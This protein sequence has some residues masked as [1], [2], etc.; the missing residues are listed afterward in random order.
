METLFIYIAKSSGLIA[1]FFLAYYFLL[2]KE[3]FFTANR[4]FL[5][6]GLFTSLIL[7]WIVFTTI[8]WVDPTPSDIDWSKIPMTAVQEESF[9]INWYLVLAVA[10]IIGIVLFLVQFALDFYNLN[11][12]L[13][14]KTT[15]QQADHKFI[16][17][18]ENIAPFSYF[19]TI[20]YNSSLYSE[21]EMESILE[22]E[23]IHSEQYHTID[24]LITRF[25]CILFWFNPFI[26]LYKKAILQN[27]EFIAD[28]EASKNIS[29]KKAYQ[30]TLLKITAHENC[31]V[32]TNHFYQSLIKKRIVMLNKNQSKKW[33]SWK[34]AL[35]IP[36]LA[37]FVFSFQMEVIAKE[38]NQKPKAEQTASNDAD[39]YKITKNTTEA[40]LKEKA[41]TISKNYGIAV[42]FSATKRNA[43]NELT[44]ITVELRKG[45]EISN[46]RNVNSSEAIKP[47][48]IVITKDSNGKISIDFIEEDKSVEKLVVANNV[49]SSNTPISADTQIYINEEKSDKTA[50]D[51]LDPKEI[52]TMNVTKNGEKKEIRI[53]TGKYSIGDM[54]EIY[55]NGNKASQNELD[56]LESGSIERMDVT[57]SF[58]KKAIRITTK[59][60]THYQDK[61]MPV[62]PVPPTAPV[63]KFKTPVAPVFPKAPKAPKGDPINGDKK[64]WKDFEKKMED[65]DAKMKKLEP[66]MEAF[67]KQMAEF[68]KQ[69]EPFNK[70]M[71]V[72]NEKMKAFDKQMEE[73]L[74]DKKDNK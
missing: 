7:P 36:A 69:M 22:H 47:F 66:Q 49:V 39:V 40:E 68:D 19:N 11:R 15:Q 16:D 20:V 13:K 23:K 10:Y 59:N 32:L 1:L 30:L 25:F 73:Y 62:P 46:N 67:D 8:V 65:Y 57:N 5:L 31:V 34:Y 27:L 24:V 17:L 74:A 42:Q 14:G 48:G 18:K 6:A 21:A 33:N 41:E 9:E 26:W 58:G 38:K 28:S 3:T 56:Q 60:G 35:I 4:W 70:E 45:T 50:M 54:N 61:N 12:V 44:A 64:A 43:N 52:A 53:I 63:M 71:E 29:D 37:A 55:I 2:R 72:F 51:K